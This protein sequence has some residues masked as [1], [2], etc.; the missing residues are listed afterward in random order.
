MVPAEP[1]AIADFGFFAFLAYVADKWPL[2]SDL[3]YVW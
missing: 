2:F 3:R 1:S